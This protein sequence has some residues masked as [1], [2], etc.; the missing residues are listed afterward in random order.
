MS[1][2]AMRSALALALEMMKHPENAMTRLVFADSLEE[3]GF[4]EEATDQRDKATSDLKT[5]KNLLA[6]R[7]T[8]EAMARRNR[9][10]GN[11]WFSQD[12]KRFFGSRIGMVYQGPGG[13]YF[14]SSEKDFQGKRRLY[15]VRRFDPISGSVDV[16]DSESF[17]EHGTSRAANR[18]AEAL[19]RTEPSE[20]AKKLA[21]LLDSLKLD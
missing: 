5:W 14:V 6:E 20:E 1:E 2:E 12:T 10:V 3:A 21:A 9:E 17:Q 16:P 11:H 8:E 13:V 15:T 7:W 18:R 4:N 19:A